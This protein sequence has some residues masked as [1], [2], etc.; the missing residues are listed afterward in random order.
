M[1]DIATG[2]AN[3]HEPTPEEQGKDPA[4]V[5][6]GKLGGAKG[7]KVR[8]AN[9]TL[10]ARKWEALARTYEDMSPISKPWARFARRKIGPAAGLERATPALCHPAPAGE[11]ELARL[12]ALPS[13]SARPA[14]HL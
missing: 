5:A 6:R 4:A 8:A 12:M 9:R 13:A 2:E 7:G 1:V 10:L 3:D 14:A 11:L